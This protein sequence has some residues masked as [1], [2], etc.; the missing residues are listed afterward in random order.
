[1]NGDFRKMKRTVSILL[2][3]GIML[4]TCACSFEGKHNEEKIGSATTEAV[5]DETDYLQTLKKMDDGGKEFRI[6]VTTQL[7]RFYD[8]S[9]SSSVVVD[10][11]AYRRNEAV[12]GLFNTKLTYTAL[13]GN[14][15]GSSAF[16]TN[17]RTTTLSGD[18][19]CYDLII[20][21]NYYTLPLVSEGMYHNLM[22]SD[23]F[24]WEAEWYHQS[25]NN[26]GM[27]NGKLWGGSGSF[28]VSQLAYAMACF[29]SKNVYESYNFGYDLYELARN[30]QWTYEIF[31]ELVSAFNTLDDTDNT[32]AYGIIKFDHAVNGTIIGM[33]VEFISKDSDGDWSFD[34]FYDSG[35]EDIYEKVRALFND[36]PAAVLETNK[37]T[38]ARSMIMSRTLFVQT[39]VDAILTDE[40]LMPNDNFVIGILPM[41]KLNE[42][43]ENYRT[44]VM[45]D[46][47]FLIPVMADL[48]RS[49]LV[50]EALNYTTY[51]I[52]NE[53]Y[54][55]TALKYR[56][57]DT[58][59]DM[60]MLSIISGTVYKDTAQYFSSDLLFLPT[61]VGLE[62]MN[63]TASF[64]TWWAKNKKAL[65]RQLDALS[66]IY[67]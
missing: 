58:E 64:S 43:Q 62:I 48:E 52:V 5:K 6:L 55:E 10:D 67:G 28:V 47:L 63:N 50:T 41:P 40:L 18:G 8:Q 54:W 51:S 7:E 57:A 22:E 1:M 59:N 49:A 3:L 61:Q 45:R 12:N 21:Q 35:F 24:N 2:F 42:E 23:S 19:D 4:C 31:L 25:I 37:T 11:A 13:D 20:G 46:E 53:A 34:N 32:N 56:S 27:I 14:S 66:D 15:S 36:Y 30:G 60:E 16:S 33:G 38:M 26:G 39:L 9:N 44:R 29:Y 17:I 65:N